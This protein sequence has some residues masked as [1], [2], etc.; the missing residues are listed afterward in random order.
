MGFYLNKQ[1]TFEMYKM[2]KF[3]LNKS[4][5]RIH[6]PLNCKQF[7][8]KATKI[9]SEPELSNGFI[10]PKPILFNPYKSDK[11]LQSSL[12]QNLPKKIK[13]MSKTICLDWENE[14][15]T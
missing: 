11:L 8:C 12:K 9:I 4:T 3:S 14:S 5:N 1:Y 10:Q 6:H 15:L 2:G 7:S 13:K